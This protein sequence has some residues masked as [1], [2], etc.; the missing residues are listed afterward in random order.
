[1]RR[2]S[3]ERRGCRGSQGPDHRGHEV[4]QEKNTWILFKQH[5]SRW[6]FPSDAIWLEVFQHLAA[7]WER[8]GRWGQHRCEGREGQE[9][10]QGDQL[11]SQE[12]CLFK[13]GKEERQ[14]RAFRRASSLKKERTSWLKGSNEGKITRT[15]WLVCR[16][17]MLLAARECRGSTLSPACT[18]GRESCYTPCPARLHGELS[19][20]NSLPGTGQMS[21]PLCTGL[22]GVG[23]GVFGKGRCL[24][25]RQ[26]CWLQRQ[27]PKSCHNVTVPVRHLAPLTPSFSHLGNDTSPRFVVRMKEVC[28]ELGRALATGQA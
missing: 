18:P 23:G 27:R 4:E 13:G 25:P 15:G 10:Q 8:D 28:K 11:G 5:R 2:G 6:R 17:W 21:A 12:E 9:W 19:F 1:M 24:Q 7:V 20:I 22:L 14:P 26:Q 16:C 3:S